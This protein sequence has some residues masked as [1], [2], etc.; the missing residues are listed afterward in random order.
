MMTATLTASNLT[1]VRGGRRLFENLCFSVVG[2]GIMALTGPNGAGKTSLLR[3]LAGLLPPAAGDVRIAADGIVAEDAEDRAH[4]VGWLGCETA[5]KPQL[6][7]REQLGFFAG[8]Y[9][10]CGA[11]QALERFDLTKT[12]DLPARMLSAGQKR[13]ASLARLMLMGR[14]VW[15][16]DEPLV[17]L[18]EEGRGLTRRAIEAHCREGGLAVVAGHDPLELPC[19][20]LHLEGA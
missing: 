4:L 3:M 18:D 2:G 14:P 6:T 16:L 1:C 15:L 8:L 20:H 7:L 11:E 12:A 17:S 5:L 10:A 13:R 9:C 19:R